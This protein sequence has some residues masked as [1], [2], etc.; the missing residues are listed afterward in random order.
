M[1]RLYI[2]LNAGFEESLTTEEERRDFVIRRAQEIIAPY[3]LEWESIGKF[4]KYRL[5]DHTPVDSRLGC[6]RAVCK[7]TPLTRYRMVLCVQSW[8]KGGEQFLRRVGPRIHCRRC[9]SSS[10]LQSLFDE[11]LTLSRRLTHTRLRP[12]K[13]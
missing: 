13:A 4:S 6:R 7:A 11:K 3:T 8:P 5:L 1:T 9:M 10:P 2:E 12:H